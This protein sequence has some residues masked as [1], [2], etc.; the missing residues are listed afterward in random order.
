MVPSKTVEEKRA[1]EPSFGTAL[2]VIVVDKDVWEIHHFEALF[3][4]TTA[5]IDVF[6]VHKEAI[7]HRSYC[8]RLLF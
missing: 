8:T 2:S 3:P 6:H 5:P 4:E 7:I 1:E